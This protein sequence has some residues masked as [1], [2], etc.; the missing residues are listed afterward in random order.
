MEMDQMSLEEDKEVDCGF[1]GCENVSYDTVLSAE[2]QQ[3]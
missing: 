2:L 1:Y 3:K